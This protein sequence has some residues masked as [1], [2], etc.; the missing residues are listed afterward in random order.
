MLSARELLHQAAVANGTFV[1]IDVQMYVVSPGRLII[2][3]QGENRRLVAG[4]ASLATSVL[5]VRS[6]LRL[7]P[8][9]TGRSPVPG[10]GFD[11][12]L[13]NFPNLA[14][15]K[16]VHPRPEGR[17]FEGCKRVCLQVAHV[18]STCVILDFCLVAAVGAAH[19][20]VLYQRILRPV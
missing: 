11:L 12:E 8:V 16:G 3:T 2:V 20:R 13:V 1:F 17:L 4:L 9:L 10:R 6:D 18:I 7:S 15:I 14:S 19:D 5:S